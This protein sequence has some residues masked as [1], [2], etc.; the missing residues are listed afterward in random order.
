MVSAFASQHDGSGFEWLGP[1][2][3]EFV[4]SHYIWLDFLLMV[5][6]PPTVKTHTGNKLTVGVIVFISAYICVRYN[7]AFMQC[8]QR[9]TVQPYETLKWM[10]YLKVAGPETYQEL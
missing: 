9:C 3:V 7:L 10:N 1:F 4:C 5:F 6:F 8:T 2:C